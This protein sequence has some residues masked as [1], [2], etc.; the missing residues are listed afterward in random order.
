MPQVRASAARDYRGHFNGYILDVLGDVLFEGLSLAHLEELR[1]KLRQRPVSE[2]TIRNVIDGSLRAMIRDAR[3]D[4]IEA[5]FPFPN[6]TWPA[7]IVPGPSPFTAEERDE[8]LA[9]FRNKRWKVGGFNDTQP[10]YPYFAFLDARTIFVD[11]S[12]HLGQEAATK[13]AGSRRTVR[14][15]RENAVANGSTG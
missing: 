8:L 6:M 13:T 3:R 5:G 9:H 11:R 1:T 10:H 15:T 7:K 2:K 4:D 12:R 14:L